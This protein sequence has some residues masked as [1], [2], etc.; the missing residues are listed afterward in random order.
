MLK[1][2][3]SLFIT[4]SLVYSNDVSIFYFHNQARC[5]TCK[6]VEANTQKVLQ[7][8]Y[9]DQLKSGKIKFSI[10]NID[11]PKNEAIVIKHK[12][13]TSSLLLTFTDKNGKTQSLNLTKEAFMNARNYSAFE[14]IL[15]QNINKILE[16]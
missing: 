3:L 9:N 14:N 2:I 15:S 13:V 10:I 11:D 6:T 5:I 8:K 4:F 12:V 16:D 1:F 7:T